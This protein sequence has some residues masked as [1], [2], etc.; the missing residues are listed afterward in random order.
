M[1]NTSEFIHNYSFLS[2]TNENE[3]MAG[4]SRLWRIQTPYAKSE[5]STDSAGRP[6]IPSGT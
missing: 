1:N 4:T 6:W 5:K 2:G 3:E